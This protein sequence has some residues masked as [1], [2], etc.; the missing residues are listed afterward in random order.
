MGQ[1]FS[2][3][4][5]NILDSHTFENLTP[6]IDDEH[7]TAVTHV[8]VD[9][10]TNK[11]YDPLSIKSARF[12]GTLEDGKT[13]SMACLL[14][15][16]SVLTSLHSIFDFETNKYFSRRDMT[17]T[18]VHQDKLYTYRLGA[19]IHDGTIAMFNGVYPF[20]YARFNLIGTPTADLGGG[21]QLDPNQHFGT[22]DNR[23]P[24]I[25]HAISGPILSHDEQ[26]NLVATQIISASR[27]TA[28]LSQYYF[29]NQEGDHIGGN[30][31]SNQAIVYPN[32]CV[33]YA[34]HIGL[35]AMLQKRFG[36]KISEYLSAYQRA[37]A[38]RNRTP[39]PLSLQA[40]THKTDLILHIQREKLRNS[41]ADRKSIEL[42][43]K[44]LKYAS[45]HNGTWIGDI[46][47]KLKMRVVDSHQSQ[48][49]YYSHRNDKGYFD[50]YF[51]TDESPILNALANCVNKIVSDYYQRHLKTD[52]PV[53]NT[54]IRRETRFV[55]DLDI[56]IGIDVP[57]GRIRTTQ[58]FIDGFGGPNY[59]IYPVVPEYLIGARP[60]CINANQ[61]LAEA[62]ELE[63]AAEQTRKKS[64]NYRYGR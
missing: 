5:G 45:E 37:H 46:P 11:S 10:S 52:N 19:I 56:E 39:V 50:L 40:Q 21:L 63:L 20:D 9:P 55:V 3:P 38:L 28:A 61:E 16:G 41:G 14:Q 4:S 25:T 34:L 64:L 32:S 23:E 26:G 53:E 36:M 12:I 18:F 48:H 62:Q 33:L 51:G 57:A 43:L 60:I 29:F 27:N 58:V 30:G 42:F 54:R 31:F 44:Q 49:L 6:A 1:F 8:I 35:D 22:A 15:D 7:R 2:K 59:H 47:E 24:P 17:V 13:T